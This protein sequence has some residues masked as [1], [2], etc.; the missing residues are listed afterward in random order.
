MQRRTGKCCAWELQALPAASVGEDT[1]PMCVVPVA[2]GS[3]DE[4]RAPRLCGNNLTEKFHVLS[5]TEVTESVVMCIRKVEA[6]RVYQD[7][8]AGAA[9]AAVAAI[10]RRLELSSCFFG[11][12]STLGKA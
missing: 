7:H 9:A 5:A 1:A 10:F 2:R 3:S 4:D 12:C 8:I 6:S 11:S